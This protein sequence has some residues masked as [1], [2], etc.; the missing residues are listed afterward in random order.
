MN[1]SAFSSLL[2]QFP[3]I[4]AVKDEKGL[5]ASLA[6]ECRVVFVL[7]GSLLDIPGIVE[8]IAGA[9]KAAIVHIDLIDGLAAKE[10]AVDYIFRTTP[11]CGIISTKGL[12]IKRAKQLGLIAIQRFFLLD[13]LAVSNIGKQ[14]RLNA[15]DVI[16]IIPGAMPKIIGV[17]AASSELPVIAGGLIQ[18]SADAM[19]ALNAGARAISSTKSEIWT[20]F[21]QLCKK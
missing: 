14:V 5:V 13:S 7:Y 8:R 17:I 16:E 2:S 20:N 3:I 21:A 18:D 6:S 12:L 19:N 11:A 9:N 4:A 15:P 1:A 10:T